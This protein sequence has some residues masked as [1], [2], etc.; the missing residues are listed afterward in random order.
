MEE[1]EIPQ[2]LELSAE[3][4]S[5]DEEKIAPPSKMLRKKKEDEESLDDRFKLRNGKEVALT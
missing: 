1:D 5:F 3:E 2:F 4:P